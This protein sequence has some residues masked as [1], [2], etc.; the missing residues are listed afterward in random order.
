MLPIGL[1]PFV[2]A[3]L[4]LISCPVYSLRVLYMVQFL[5]LPSPPPPPGNPR[6]KIG[7][8]GPEVGN[9]SSSLVGGRGWGQVEIPTSMKTYGATQWQANLSNLLDRNNLSNPCPECKCDQ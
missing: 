8:S 9:F 2:L 3:F 5:L 1:V 7:P 6:D 4:V